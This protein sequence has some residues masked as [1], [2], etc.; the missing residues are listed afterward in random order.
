MQLPLPDQALSTHFSIPFDMLRKRQ[1]HL[2]DPRV[3]RIKQRGFWTL[4]RLCSPLPNHI[5]NS[6][7]DTNLISY[8]LS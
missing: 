7:L 2:L 3:V 6:D 8:S 1:V 5:H 4:G